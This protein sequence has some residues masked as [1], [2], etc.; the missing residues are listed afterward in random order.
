MDN[1]KCANATSL[2]IDA[3]GKRINCRNI[4]F[5]EFWSQHHKCAFNESKLPRCTGNETI[6]EYEQE[7][8]VP[9][10]GLLLFLT[11][12]FRRLKFSTAF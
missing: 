7:G 12:I 6:N 3:N 4:W 1:D 5:R 11:I 9:F 8:L 2:P 10:V